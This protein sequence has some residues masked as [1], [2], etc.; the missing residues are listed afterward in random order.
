MPN[1]YIGIGSNIDAET[2]L[3]ACAEMLRADFPGITFSNVYKTAARDAEDQDD[4]LNAVAKIETDESIEDIYET[5]Q[6]IE[7]DLGKDPPYEKGPRTIDLD[8][9]LH[10]NTQHPTPNAQLVIPHPRMH[11]RRFV[12]EPLCELCNDNQWH[13]ELQKTLD[14]SCEKA[15]ITL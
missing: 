6:Q 7:I 1:C 5:L 4:F 13:T 2:N 9:L 3:A 8:I 10:P 11:E 14:Q 15:G 12:L